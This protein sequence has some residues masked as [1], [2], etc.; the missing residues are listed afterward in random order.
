MEQEKK[1]VHRFFSTTIDQNDFAFMGP[2]PHFI[3]GACVLFILLPPGVDAM[4]DSSLVP[5]YYQTHGLQHFSVLSAPPTGLQMPP[6]R[7]HT[8]SSFLIFSSAYLLPLGCTRSCSACSA[9][10]SAHPPLKSHP[11]EASS[12]RFVSIPSLGGMN[13]CGFSYHNFNFYQCG[14]WLM[15]I[16]GFGP[17]IQ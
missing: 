7:N 3:F 2:L 5:F 8:N 6:L 9:S 13:T 12:L 1:L 10:C 15:M 17:S 11:G 14:V 4:L 16:H